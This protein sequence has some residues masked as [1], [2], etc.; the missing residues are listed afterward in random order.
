MAEDT[1]QSTIQFGGYDTTYLKNPAAGIMYL[2]L[3]DNSLFWNI[4]IDGFKVGTNSKLKNG[5]PNGY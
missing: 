5:A 3:A 4:N 2:A 1:Q